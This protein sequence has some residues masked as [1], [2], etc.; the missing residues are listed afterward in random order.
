MLSSIGRIQRAS[1]RISLVALLFGLA[2]ALPGEAGAQTWQTLLDDTTASASWSHMT[3]FDDGSAAVVSRDYLPGYTGAGVFFRTLQGGSWS[4]PVRLDGGLPTYNGRTAE[5]MGRVFVGSANKSSLGAAPVEVIITARYSRTILDADG[6]M[7]ALFL[8]RWNGYAWSAW[9]RITPVG[10]INDVSADVDGQGRVWYTWNDG[11]NLTNGQYRLSSYDPAAGCSG[12][13]HTLDAASRTLTWRSTS[14]VIAP[15]AIWVTYRAP[16]GIYARRLAHQGAGPLGPRIP[17][18]LGFPNAQMS[19]WVDG[20]LWVTT[21]SPLR[22]Y[23]LS[24]GAFVQEPV[25]GLPSYY[26]ETE[27]SLESVDHYLP[28]VAQRP[29]SGLVLIAVRQH[30]FEDWIDSANDFDE[31]SLV[32]VERSTAGTWSGPATLEPD[33]TWS[34]IGSAASTSA[35]GLFIG[36]TK[37]SGGLFV[38]RRLP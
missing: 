1:A 35:A 4:A 10:T 29:G 33:E 15:D 25:V 11:D 17:V 14:L 30:H 13:V 28:V 26:E 16:D 20:T 5:V 34:D 12:A 38:L 8:K 3:A 24:G 31:S 37:S 23:R 19:A 21:E 6:L 2:A 27:S 32:A 9:T 7:Y 36:G 18:Q 22:L